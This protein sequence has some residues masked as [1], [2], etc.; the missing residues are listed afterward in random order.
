MIILDMLSQLAIWQERARSRYWLL[1]LD[2]HLM[3]DIGMTEHLLAAE[4]RKPWWRA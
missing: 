2:D 3:Q 4:A 1:Q